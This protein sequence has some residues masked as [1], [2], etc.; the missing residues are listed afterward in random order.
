VKDVLG[1]NEKIENDPVGLFA[2]VKKITNLFISRSLLDLAAL[3]MRMV[4]NAL[5]MEDFL[6]QLKMLLICVMY[7]EKK[8]R[9]GKGRRVQKKK[10][11]YKNEN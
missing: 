3:I 5:H 2:Y 10:K 6:M 1:I 4:L 7:Q 11:N 8:G 9:E